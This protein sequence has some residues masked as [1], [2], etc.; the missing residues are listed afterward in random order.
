ME[1]NI[2]AI[3]IIVF[4]VGIPGG[5][6]YLLYARIAEYFMQSGKLTRRLNKRIRGGYI[7]V[8]CVTGTVLFA[9]R[10]YRMPSKDR[11]EQ[12]TGIALPEKLR[13]L[14]DRYL[15]LWPDYDL[16]YNLQL[17]KNGTK[18]WIKAIRAS[19]QYHHELAPS[20]DDM[21]HYIAPKKAAWYNSEN[22]FHFE[23]R[24]QNGTTYLVDLDTL[25]NRLMYNESMD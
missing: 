8:L 19:K 17:D 2:I 18:A 7:V 15:D 9:F 13:V 11:L 4:I 20:G 1:D 10:D 23:E 14:K 3:V 12:A 24:N 5:I 16:Q 6:L 22:G 21:A 25:S